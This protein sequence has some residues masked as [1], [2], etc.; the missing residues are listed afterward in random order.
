LAASKSVLF[1]FSQIG[2]IYRER[3]AYTGNNFN[4]DI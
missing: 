1:S 4:S 2:D 3:I